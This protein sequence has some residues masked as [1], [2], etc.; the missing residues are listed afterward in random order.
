MTIL[1]TTKKI[2]KCEARD[3]STENVKRVKLDVDNIENVKKGQTQAMTAKEVVAQLKPYTNPQDTLQKMMQHL[4]DL[5]RETNDKAIMLTALRTLSTYVTNLIEKPLETSYKTVN[6]RNLNFHNRVGKYSAAVN[7]LKLV[8]FNEVIENENDDE[9]TKESLI[10]DDLDVRLVSFAKVTI[11]AVIAAVKED[12]EGITAQGEATSSTSD[13]KDKGKASVE[14]VDKSRLLGPED[15]EDEDEDTETA[16]DHDDVCAICHNEGELLMCDGCPNSF[17]LECCTP[18]LKSVPE[19][20]WFCVACAMSKASSGAVNATSSSSSST[21]GHMSTDLVGDAS[22]S[23]TVSE[24]STHGHS[25]VHANTGISD[26]GSSS[27]SE[28]MVLTEIDGIVAMGYPRELVREVYHQ[29]GQ[30]VNR[31]VDVLSV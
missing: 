16:D 11:D 17:H 24:S 2:D 25:D 27:K 19:G 18:K 15:Y 22:A 28:E 5:R 12:V 1:E 7:F 4:Q 6:L 14:E 9:Q 20:D 13:D 10:I 31:T 26:Q 29:N 8:G 3:E 30:D 23:V 21:I